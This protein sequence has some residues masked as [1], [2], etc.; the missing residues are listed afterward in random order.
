MGRITY[1]RTSRIMTIKI[2]RL[3]DDI[4]DGD[5]DGKNCVGKNTARGMD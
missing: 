2:I 4:D 5:D 1:I 3:P